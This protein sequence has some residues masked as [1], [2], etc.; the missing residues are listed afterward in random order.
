MGDHSKC[1]IGT[2]FNT[3]TVVDPACAIFD[4]GFP[5][6]HLPPF[7]WFNARTEEM[8]IQSLDRMLN[9]AAKVMGRR[10]VTMSEAQRDN[11]TRLYHERLPPG[12]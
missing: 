12:S 6:K 2:T 4:S 1:G 11:L 10:G 3:G 5:P 7:S 9:T 8:Q